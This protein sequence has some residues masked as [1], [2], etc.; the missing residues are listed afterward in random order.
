MVI[1][2]RRVTRLA[3]RYYS[4][5]PSCLDFSCAIGHE[6]PYTERYLRHHMQPLQPCNPSPGQAMSDWNGR[7][8]LPS[9][10]SRGITIQAFCI[11]NI[12]AALPR[13]VVPPAPRS[14][15]WLQASSRGPYLG[16]ERRVISAPLLPS[17][18]GTPRASTS[19]DHAGVSDSSSEGRCRLPTSHKASCAT[20]K[21]VLCYAE[22]PRQR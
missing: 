21:L 18:V 16:G 17:R 20:T 10:F 19:K 8:A 1:L 7:K 22:S 4:Y 5:R 14:V 2:I 13:P 12:A 3:G 11:I 15:A 9:G 6:I